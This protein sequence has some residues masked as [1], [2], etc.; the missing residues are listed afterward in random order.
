MKIGGLILMGGK[1][2]RMGGYTKGLLRIQNMTFLEK[3][4]AVFDR[5]P[6]VYLSINSK[7][8]KDSKNI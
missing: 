7:F 1:N 2:S 4:V 6:N 5:F 8:T 3:I